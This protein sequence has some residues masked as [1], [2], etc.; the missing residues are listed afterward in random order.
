M[1]RDQLNSFMPSR[2]IV[3]ESTASGCKTPR[4]RASMNEA[5]LAPSA[6]LVA[7]AIQQQVKSAATG[8]LSRRRCSSDTR[9][10]YVNGKC[11]VVIL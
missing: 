8:P 4:R 10:G 11:W 2:A 9:T 3:I 1:Q 6:A 5:A 7:Q